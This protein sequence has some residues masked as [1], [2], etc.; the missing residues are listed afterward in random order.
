MVWR[1][2]QVWRP[3]RRESAG[4]GRVPGGGVEEEEEE[5]GR[6][7]AAVPARVANEAGEAE[8]GSV[9]VDEAE[10]GSDEEE[11]GVLGAPFV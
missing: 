5:R 9:D 11:A 3:R 8:A 10:A 7:A 1:K 4:Q 6:V 2:V